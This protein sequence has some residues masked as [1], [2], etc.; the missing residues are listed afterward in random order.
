M[1]MTNRCSLPPSSVS[2]WDLPN[3]LCFIRANW[4]F[5]LLSV[6]WLMKS[7]MQLLR[8]KRK[9]TDQPLAP[10]LS[11]LAQARLFVRIWLLVQHLITWKTYHFSPTVNRGMD[12]FFFC[13]NKNWFISIT[14]DD[15]GRGWSFTK[16][17][18]IF[19]SLLGC[20]T[21]RNLGI[22]WEDH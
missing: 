2:L 9:A 14:S 21:K 10:W 11:V 13:C 1:K 4:G 17:A 16:R 18:A 6:C 20:D 15:L 12:T 7:Q 5:T 22:Y 19:L 3:I 8:S